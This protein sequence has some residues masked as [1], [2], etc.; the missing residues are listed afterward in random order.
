LLSLIALISALTLDCLS[1]SSHTERS[2]L[3]ES[4]APEF[5]EALEQGSDVHEI[6]G[7]YPWNPGDTAGGGA[8]C[9]DGKAQLVTR[10]RP[11]PMLIVE[12]VFMRA[13]N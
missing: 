4:C 3:T 5:E 11:S 6:G 9:G 2:G 10:V 13:L 12:K 1:E 7:G 8:G